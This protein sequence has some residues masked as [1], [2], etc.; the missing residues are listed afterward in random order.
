MKQLLQYTL[1]TMLTALLSV[2]PALAQNS[3]FIDQQD[4]RYKWNIS[5][6]VNPPL[7]NVKAIYPHPGRDA[8]D[9]LLAETDYQPVDI[10]IMDLNGT[11]VKTF[12]LQPEGNLMTI[13]VSNL[14]P[15]QYALHVQETGRE[16]QKMVLLREE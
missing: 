15:G 8:V 4:A 6:T 3:E 13:D 9:I 2:A 5:G 10:R 7:T 16:V 14:P 12:R 1:I 11:V